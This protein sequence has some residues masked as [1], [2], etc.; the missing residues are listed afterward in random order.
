[1]KI[2][3]LRYLWRKEIFNG[4]IFIKIVSFLNLFF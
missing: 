2:N 3:Q 4:R 1:M